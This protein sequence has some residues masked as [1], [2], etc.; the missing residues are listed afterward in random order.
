[1]T[2]LEAV[3]LGILQG[4]TEFLPVSSSGHLALMQHFLGL[5]EPQL[6]FDVMLHLGTLGAVIIAYKNSIRELAGASLSAVINLQFYRRPI[7][8]IK[9]STD[10]KL[11]C[12]ILLGS[13]PTGAI[14]IAFKPQLEALFVKPTVVAMMLITTG[15]ILQL[16]RFRRNPVDGDCPVRF[17]HSP[18]IGIAQGLAITPGISRSGATIS[19]ALLL[20]SAPKQ[21]ARFSFL[22]SIPAILGAVLLKLKDVASISVSPMAVAFGTL[23]AFAVGY[24]ALR[25]L[26]AVLDRGKFTGF[27]YYCFALGMGVL[28][29]RMLS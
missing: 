1:M 12:F 7:S 8:T 3:I 2:I 16:P 17:W 6:F 9:G 14:A 24:I 18:L 5:R 26:L 15:V 4:V 23:T 21:A 29:F 27:S 10:L 25:V 20:G 28:I 11:I 19:L 22:L 13:V